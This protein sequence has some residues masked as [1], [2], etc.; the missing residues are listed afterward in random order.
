MERAATESRKTIAVLTPDYVDSGWGEF[1][2]IMVQTLDPAARDRRL[3]PL[4]LAK[5]EPPL[6]IRS[7]SYIDFT[8]AE[9]QEERF[10]QLID[11][12]R[13]RIGPR[14]RRGVPAAADL[15]FEIPT[16]ALSSDS[17]VYIERE[18]DHVLEQQVIREGSTTVVQGARQT[19]KSSLLV[20][21]LTYAR[22]RQC[23]AVYIDLQRVP[24]SSIEDLDTLSRYLADVFHTRLKTAVPPDQMWERSAPCTEK[25]N[26]YVE[27]YILEGTESQVVLVLDEADRLFARPFTDDF[28]GLLRAWHNQRAAIPLWRKLNLVLAISTDPRHAIKDLRQSPFSNIGT[29]AP[30]S[31]FSP[32]EVWELNKR[33]GRPLRR[34]KQAEMLMDL[35]GGQPYLVQRALYA[36]A[37]QTHTLEEL[38]DTRSAAL[39]PFADHL[40]HYRSLLESDPALR[41]AMNQA[42]RNKQCGSYDVFS[43]LRSLGFVLGPDHQKVKPTC[44]LYSDYFRKVLT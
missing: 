1:E 40:A 41:Q 35:V 39:G 4:L 38:L 2:N 36:L 8:D 30:L 15:P 43:R 16:G 28:F 19:G 24:E 31:E 32:E 9:V 12:V 3:I 10:E 37:A 14:R 7:L 34:K 27:N 11:A 25:L 26:D 23:A 18:H 21:V 17:P 44:R 13:R 42:M 29:K 22:S 20:R 6:R 33:Y 5:C